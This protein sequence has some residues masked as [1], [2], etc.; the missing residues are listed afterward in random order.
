MDKL[1]NYGKV[2]VAAPYHKAK[3][4]CLPQFFAA[5]NA[6][7]YQNKEIVLRVD[8][9]EYGSDNAVKKQR[10]FFRNLCLAGDFEYLYFM[11]IDTIPPEGVLERLLAT[12][13]A[14]DIKVIGGVYWGRHNAENGTPEGAVAWIHELSQEEQT[15]VFSTTGTLIEVDGQGMDCVLIHRSIL[16]KISWL[17]WEQND[18]DYP[19]YDKCK[20]LGHKVFIDTSI[21]CKHYFKST[22][23]TH[24]AKVVEL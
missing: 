10:E 22:G 19:F 24:L 9:C 7:T 4:Y 21:Q 5:A 2:L 1:I 11:G 23:Y 15:K 8:P 17:D 6:L 20:A 14:N 12:A 13:Q 16:E 3:D 18:D